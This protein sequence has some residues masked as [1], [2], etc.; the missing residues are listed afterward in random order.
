MWKEIEFK[1]LKI[2]KNSGLR[3]AFLFKTALPLTLS[4][5]EGEHLLE[6]YDC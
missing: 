6:S 3:L 2:H 5:R 4:Q 1:V